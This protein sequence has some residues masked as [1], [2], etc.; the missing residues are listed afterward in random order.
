MSCPDKLLPTHINNHRPNNNSYTAL[1]PDGFAADKNKGFFS[2]FLHFVPLSFSFFFLS[3]GKKES[4]VRASLARKGEWK[5][6][7]RWVSRAGKFWRSRLAWIQPLN[8]F[9]TSKF[10][11][12]I[13]KYYRGESCLSRII[14][15]KQKKRSLST[16]SKVEFGGVLIEALLDQ[17]KCCRN[18]WI[19]DWRRY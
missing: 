9:K 7:R 8:L 6:G 1:G 14:A 10:S 2:F 11:S 15:R 19:K 17:V 12:V 3:V 13:S 18:S 5:G 16:E 4:G